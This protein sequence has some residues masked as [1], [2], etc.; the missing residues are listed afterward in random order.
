MKARISIALL[1]T[2]S[3]TAGAAGEMGEDIWLIVCR[4]Q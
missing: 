1:T 3:R 4:G 2:L